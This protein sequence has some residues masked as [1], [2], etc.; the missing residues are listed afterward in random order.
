MSE[1]KITLEWKRELEDF[2]YESYNRDHELVFEGGFRVPASAAPAYRG[3]P[4]HVNPEEATRPA[5][6][7]RRS[8]GA[9]GAAWPVGLPGASAHHGAL[10]SAALNSPMV[11]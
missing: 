9:R 5:S 4:A 3:N 2:S 10:N 1:H 6:M 7:A 11:L 8:S